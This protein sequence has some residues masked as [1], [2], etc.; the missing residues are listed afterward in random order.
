MAAAHEASADAS[1]DA[2]AG[3]QERVGGAPTEPVL[4]GVDATA[5]GPLEADGDGG[6]AEVAGAGSPG[7]APVPGPTV[8]A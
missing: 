1:V 3:T 4:A 5:D 7:P 8:D 2:S 6:G